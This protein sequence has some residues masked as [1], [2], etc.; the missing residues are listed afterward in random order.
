MIGSSRK[1]KAK[2]KKKKGKK[3]V[4]KTNIVVNSPTEVVVE[5]VVDVLDVQGS[6]VNTDKPEI[7]NY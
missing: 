6:S 7:K 2:K 3:R 4:K 1:I 5:E